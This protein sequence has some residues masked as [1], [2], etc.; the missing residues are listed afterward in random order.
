IGAGYD[1]I[2]VTPSGLEDVS[3]YPH[4]LAELLSDPDWSEK[5]ILSLAGLNFLRV[6]EKVE[7]IRDRWKKAEIAPFEELGPKNELEECVSKSS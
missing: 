6:F 3:K 5:D 1:G 4:L 7:E 2:N